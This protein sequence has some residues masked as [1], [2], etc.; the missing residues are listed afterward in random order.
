MGIENNLALQAAG[1]DMVKA[2][3][4][5]TDSRMRLLPVIQGFGSF[6]DNFEPGTG[7]SDGSTIG[8]ALGIDMPY[9]TTKGV[10]YVTSAGL[11]LSMPLYNQGIYSGISIAGKLEEI[12]GYSYEKA[13]EDLTVEISSQYFLGQATFKQQSL[14]QDNIS[15][16]EQLEQITVAFYDNGMALEV[17]VKRVGINLENL[18]TQLEDVQ[19]RYERQLNLIRYILNLPPEHEFALEPIPET[20]EE[21][22]EYLYAGLSSDLY[23]LKILNAQQELTERQLK[24]I[25]SGYIPSLALVGQTSYTKATNRFADYF[26]SNTPTDW[27]NNTYLGLAL[28]IPVF[29]GMAKRNK[30]KQANIDYEKL[31]ITKNDIESKLNTQYMNALSEWNTH[32]LNLKKQRGNYQLAEDVYVVTSDRYKE[33]IASMT[34]LLQDE[35]RVSEAQSN[36]ISSLFQYMAAEL[37]VLKLTGQL[38]QLMQ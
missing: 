13:K 28:N 4:N 34:E 8:K 17:D 27:Y 25:K 20:P 5:K 18:R 24:A 16:L 31:Q 23:E 15:R 33:G 26:E 11:Q 2:D 38:D 12:T 21:D 37:R 19:S 22:T 9:L 36:Y 32:S 29:D 7:V 6:T 14:V 1:K 35:L 3:I 10:Q 30:V